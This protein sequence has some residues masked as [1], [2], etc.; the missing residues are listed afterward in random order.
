MENQFKKYED[1]IA[2]SI[3]RDTVLATLALCAIILGAFAVGLLY[4]RSQT[5]VTWSQLFLF[6][7]ILTVVI[8]LTTVAQAYLLYHIAHRVARKSVAPLIDSLDREKAFT[9]FASHELRTPLAVIKGSLE[10]LIRKQRKEEEYRQKIRENLQVVDNM[11]QMVDN[12]LTLTRVENGKL[13]LQYTDVPVQDI[14]TEACTVSS[15]VMLQ[16][17]LAVR[18]DVPDEHLK[19]YTDHTALL[20]ILTNVIAN[21]A[22]YC[23][24]GGSVGLTAK[25]EDGHVLI[26]VVNSGP[27]I[28]AEDTRHVFEPFYRSIASGH[29][30]I[31]GYGLGL[32]IVSR[33]AA[34]TG[35]KVSLTSSEQGP[36]T[37]R[38]HI[39]QGHP[40]SQQTFR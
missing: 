32:T 22:K 28:P 34:I 20:T 11:N 19:A 10:V 26:E 3:L 27:G 31:E 1:R 12:L 5:V 25:P 9:S 23:N 21:A 24:K 37:V 30:R 36:T 29:Q 8:S 39:P 38:L 7:V 40:S 2:H 6:M 15:D 35:I 4:F 13:R 18:L 14:L 17:E 33:F 16:R